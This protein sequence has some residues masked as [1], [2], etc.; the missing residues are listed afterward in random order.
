MRRPKNV[1]RRASSGEAGSARRRR[2]PWRRIVVIAL[3]AV[4][5]ILTL[6][7]SFNVWLKRQA[8]ETD[9]WER[10]S[11]SLIQEEAIRDAVAVTL[12]NRIFERVD[13]TQALQ[14][15]LPD[16]LAGVAPVLVAGIEDR[17]IRAAQNMLADPDVQDAWV[18]ANRAAHEKLIGVIEDATPGETMV[19]LD[20]R[21]LMLT[22][23]GRLGIQ[24][25]VEAK[26][27]PDAG[28]VEVMAGDRLEA[29]QDAV[30]AIKVLSSLLV[31]VV[32]ALYGAA[33]VIA[34][35][36]RRQTVRAVGAS[37]LA[38]GLILSIVRTVVGHALI[39]ALSNGGR[40]EPAGTATWLIGTRLLADVALAIIVLGA[41]TLV[42]S[43]LVGPSRWAVRLRTA[44][45]PTF[46]SHPARA[47]AVVTVGWLLFILWGPGEG[48]RLIGVLIIG[49]IALGIVEVMRRQCAREF[50]GA[51]AAS[52][53]GDPGPA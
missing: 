41:L 23:A 18:A 7:G 15:R 22:L 11:R 52:A 28:Q 2:M 14:Q 49:V 50:P 32:I 45:A 42:G 13:V 24:E 4:A 27:P 12:V 1:L 39:G 26:L 3:I 44:L 34:R 38:V 40:F 43:W 8:L 37:L 35:G 46:A 10:T 6:V 33:I 20:L 36:R 25:Q 48:R 16:Q 53:P 9:S 29:A 5:T 19:V 30:R 47:F 17:A 31:L 51:R 21:P